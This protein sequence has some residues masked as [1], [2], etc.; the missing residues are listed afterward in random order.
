MRYRI[1]N[2]LIIF[3]ISSFFGN[4]FSK[5]LL[6]KPKSAIVDYTGILNRSQL[7]YLKRKLKTFND[8]SST[9]IVVVID[10]SLEGED[11]F[12]YSYRLASNWGIGSK[13]KDNGVLMYIAFNDRKI[14]IQSGSGLEGVLPDAVLKRIIQNVIR[15]AFK[16]NQY[17][18]GINKS[19]DII[20]SLVSGE[21]T[22][23][24][25]VQNDDYIALLFLLVFLVIFA[26]II[27]SIFKCKKSGDCNDGGG[28]YD[29]G[30]YNTGRRGGWIIGGGGFG[31]SSGGFSGGGGFGG[32]GF[33]GFGGGG[34]SGG[35]AGGGW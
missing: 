24:D 23:D 34:F 18:K 22:A 25:Y 8:T 12:D 11:I 5:E 10:K 31:G 35:G 21:F 29:G 19:T 3:F 15:P 4:I 33:G 26:I 32:G 7:D 27:Y 14:F 28:Y 1:H 16:N 17:F 13:G 2:I 20:I 6:P 30:R 9:A